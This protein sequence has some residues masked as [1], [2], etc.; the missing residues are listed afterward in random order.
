MAITSL[1]TRGSS[2]RNAAGTQNIITVTGDIAVNEMLIIGYCSD[3]GNNTTT[4]NTNFHSVTDSKSHV[5]NKVFE[6]TITQGSPN[7]GVTLSLWFTRI[8]SPMVISVDTITCSTAESVTDAIAVSIKVAVASTN[9]LAFITGLTEFNGGGIT[10]TFSHTLPSLTS[11]E[12]LMIGWF[13]AEGATNVKTAGTNYTER[14]DLRSASTFNETNIHIHMQSR[15]AT[16]TSDTVTSSDAAS[17][18]TIQSLTA[19][20]EVPASIVYN[21]EVDLNLKGEFLDDLPLLSFFDSTFD[22]T[23]NQTGITEESSSTSWDDSFDDTFTTQEIVDRLTIIM[24]PLVTY[25]VNSGFNTINILNLFSNLILQNT[26]I[27][28]TFA[29]NI[30][31][32]NLSL[33]TQA[34]DNSSGSR[35]SNS[36]ANL[37]STIQDTF[38]INIGINGNVNLVGTGQT[39]DSISADEL[40]SS[41]NMN[42]LVTDTLTVQRLSELVLNFITTSIISTEFEGETAKLDFITENANIEDIYVALMEHLN[43]LNLN[44]DFTDIYLSVIDLLQELDLTMNINQIH[45]LVADLFNVL[46]LD[47]HTGIFFEDELNAVTRPIE[48]ETF[49]KV[50]VKLRFFATNPKL[51]KIIGATLLK[52]IKIIK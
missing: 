37:N 1:S 48:A 12:Y 13:G 24:Y 33:N 17:W 45:S 50:Y 22:F 20:Y 2:S 29:N 52:Y 4:G 32:I 35:N 19:F 25:N 51:L 8:T 41:I 11:R 5:W 30:M 16:L 31:Q 15:I 43:S 18:E 7:D 39:S 27:I 42:A 9:T 14:Y 44:I 26:N 40:F 49:L 6:R 23:F 21:E 28:S 47:I 46:K 34:L 38:L 10:T 3:N 36:I